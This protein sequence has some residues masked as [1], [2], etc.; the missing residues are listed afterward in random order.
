L[1]EEFRRK[2]RALR[3]LCQDIVELRRGDH[4]AERLRLDLERFAE[5]NKED[6]L[7]ALETVMEETKQ[8]PEVRKA[9]QDAFALY[10]QRDKGGDPAN[11]GESSQI[12]PNQ[13]V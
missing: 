7:R 1:D 11:Q 2:L 12:K 9:F 6:Q 13:T 5:A 4:H 10:R 3:T 8:W